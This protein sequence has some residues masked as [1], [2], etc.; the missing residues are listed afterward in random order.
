MMIGSCHC[1]KAQWRLEGDPGSITSCN[2]TMCRR[3]GTLWAYD[4]ED[5]RVAVTG[6]TA[7]YTRSGKDKSPLEILFCPTC[8]C[9]RLAWPGAGTGWA[10]ADGGQRQARGTR[11]GSRPSDRSFRRIGD[12]YRSAIKG[13]MR[14]R[15][16]V[17][18]CFAI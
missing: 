10:T 13:A 14:A 1:G 12:V 11:G 7:S 15:S 18:K 9:T 16:L 5:Y 6:P 3:Y 4:Y 17:L 8:A 2:C